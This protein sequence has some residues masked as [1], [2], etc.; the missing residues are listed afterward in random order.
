MSVSSKAFDSRASGDIVLSAS[1]YSARLTLGLFATVRTASTSAEK[2][3]GRTRHDGAACRSRTERLERTRTL[4]RGPY[5]C[6]LP[7][8]TRFETYRRPSP[9]ETLIREAPVYAAKRAA[10]TQLGGAQDYSG[11]FTGDDS[12]GFSAAAVGFLNRE[13]TA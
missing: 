11:V 1:M 9:L 13:R 3:T 6:C 2:Y 12:A 7:A 10:V 8:L 4:G 5:G